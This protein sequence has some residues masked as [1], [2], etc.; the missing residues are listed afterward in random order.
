MIISTKSLAYDLNLPEDYNQNGKF[1][2]LMHITIKRI[3]CSK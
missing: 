3:I 1:I 2:G